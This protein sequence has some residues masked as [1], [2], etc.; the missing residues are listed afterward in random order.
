MCGHV[1]GVHHLAGS[2]LEVG[3]RIRVVD[4]EASSRPLDQMLGVGQV[5]GDLGQVFLGRS[6]PRPVSGGHTAADRLPDRPQPF[7][8]VR[9]GWTVRR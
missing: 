7:H 8:W 2:M 5:V 6:L 3:R 4:C 1:Q 9:P